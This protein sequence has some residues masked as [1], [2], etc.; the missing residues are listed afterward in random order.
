MG[1]GTQ[2]PSMSTPEMNT[3]LDESAT[4]E[5]E[6]RRPVLIRES[7][8]YGYPLWVV[9]M[10][11]GG[12]WYRW[13]WVWVWVQVLDTHTHTHTHMVGIQGLITHFSLSDSSNSCIF[14]QQQYKKSVL[15]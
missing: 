6:T 13:V 9:G 10:G 8:G 1:T 2:P 12:Y 4:T 3:T 5:S 7:H 14:I 15:G 11:T